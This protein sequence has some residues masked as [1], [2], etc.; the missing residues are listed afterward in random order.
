MMSRE[1]FLLLRDTRMPGLPAGHSFFLDGVRMLFGR[2]VFT[3][4]GN[5]ATELAPEEKTQ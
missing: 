3:K 5:A 4:I 2:A 1:L